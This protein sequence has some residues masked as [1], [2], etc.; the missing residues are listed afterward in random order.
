MLALFEL[1][2]A[3]P[4]SWL[5]ALFGVCAFESRFSMVMA[6]PLYAYAVARGGLLFP[7]AFDWRKLR[8]FA[9]VCVAVLPFWIWYNEAR[10]GVPWDIGYTAWFHHDSWGQP[11]GSPFRLSYF[12]YEVYSFFMRPPVLTEWLQQSIPPYFKVDPNGVALTFSSPALVLAFLSQAPRTLK[13][14]LWITVV[15]VAAPSFFYYLNGWYQ[16]GMRHALDFEPFL[17]I[18]MAF[19]VRERVPRW[20]QGLIAWSV[21]M[22]VWG[23]WFWNVNF[24]SGD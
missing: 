7:V 20:G 18:L 23:I 14:A 8:G 4:R 17:L 16:Y 1:T 22:S 15:L 11:E 6:M 10:W 24:R 19:A 12:P 5:V 13:R 2:A 9:I 21:A 3:R